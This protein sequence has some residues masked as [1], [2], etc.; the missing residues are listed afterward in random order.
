MNPVVVIV[1]LTASH[2]ITSIFEDFRNQIGN[3]NNNRSH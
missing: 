3:P 1:K 2:Y